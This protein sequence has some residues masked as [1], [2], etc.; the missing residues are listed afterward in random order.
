MQSL[1]YD[2]D[3][4]GKDDYLGECIFKI[5]DKEVN[6]LMAPLKKDEE[7]CGKIILDGKFR[8]TGIKSVP[9]PTNPSI[10]IA[11]CPV[12]KISIYK[13]ELNK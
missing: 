3:L 8:K 7:E 9:L 6:K 5:P 11:K 2:D 12:Q 13:L 1:V 4:I 10:N